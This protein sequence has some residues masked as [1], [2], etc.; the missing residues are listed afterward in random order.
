MAHVSFQNVSKIYSKQS[1][2]FFFSYFLEV[3]GRKR[4]PQEVFYALRDVSFNVRDGDTL[5]I[6]G[7]NGAGKSTLLSLVAGLTVP[8]EGSV[9]VSGRVMA[10]LELGSGFHPDLTGRENL[11]MNAAL[12]GLSQKETMDATEEIIGFSEL[13]DFI[14]EPIRTY[15]QGMVLRLAFS[16]AVHVKPDILLLDEILA[17]GDKDFQKKCEKRIFELRDRGTILLVVSHIPTVL[18]ELC[19]KGLWIEKGS[20]VMRGEADEV[21]GAYLDQNGSE[22]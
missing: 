13:G 6:V 5:G 11:R 21:F 8:E 16:I 10:M 20:V 1:R 2:Q 15:S 18:R 3:L 12:C 14:E 7:H 9:S 22:R 4:R 17:V 19:A